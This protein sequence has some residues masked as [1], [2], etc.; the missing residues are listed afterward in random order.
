MKLL[1]FFQKS[2][3]SNT[4]HISCCELT[5]FDCKQGRNCPLRQKPQP[6]NA[7]SHTPPNPATHATPSATAADF[8]PSNTPSA[9]SHR[10]S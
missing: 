3:S 2:L 1:R 10:P 5:Q 6:L 8:G 4:R 7:S 9:A